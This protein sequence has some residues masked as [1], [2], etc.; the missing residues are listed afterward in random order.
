VDV[1]SHQQSAF[2]DML[3]AVL[4]EVL[5]GCAAL[6]QV[7]EPQAAALVQ[8]T[9]RQQKTILRRLRRLE[10]KLALIETRT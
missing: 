2:N 6:G 10:K 1:L 9:L 4:A 7:H 8:E 5:D 3:L